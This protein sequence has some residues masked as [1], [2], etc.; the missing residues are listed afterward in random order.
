VNAL[1]IGPNLRKAVQHGRGT[2]IP[3]FLS[4][5]PNLFRKNY[6]NLDVALISVSPPDKHGY[7]SLGVSVDTTLAAV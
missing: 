4:E 3:I 7:C 6:I 5:A 2:Y 1:F